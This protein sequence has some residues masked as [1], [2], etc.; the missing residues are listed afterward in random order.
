LAHAS[1]CRR[2]IPLT[3][4]SHML[5]PCAGRWTSKALIMCIL[6][7]GRRSRKCIITTKLSRAK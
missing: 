1:L 5:P 6:Q 3:H 7:C 2:I 4:L